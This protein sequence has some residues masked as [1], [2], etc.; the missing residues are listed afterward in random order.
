ME[1][2]ASPPKKAISP[3]S[4]DFW[5]AEFINFVNRE[6][7]E[8]FGSKTLP[9]NKEYNDRSFKTDLLKFLMSDG[10]RFREDIILNE[11]SRKIL[12]SSMSYRH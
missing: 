7:N 1:Q 10:A 9:T 6:R 12:L 5:F 11:T 3:N 2:L 8:E 4:I